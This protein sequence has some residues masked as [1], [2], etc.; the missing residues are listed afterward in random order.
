MEY[1]NVSNY[2]LGYF[3]YD[4]L[5]NKLICGGRLKKINRKVGKYKDKKGIVKEGMKKIHEF[6]NELT[7]DEDKYLEIVEYSKKHLINT[8]SRNTKSKRHKINDIKNGSYMKIRLN[9]IMITN[10]YQV[11]KLYKKDE[12]VLFESK[13]IYEFICLL[14]EA[15]REDKV[16]EFIDVPDVFYIARNL[17]FTGIAPYFI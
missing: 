4:E 15:I 2:M 12:Y 13:Y 3:N 17:A 14:D 9:T 5:S 6:L 1:V 11:Y 7:K 16:A 10:R 8:I